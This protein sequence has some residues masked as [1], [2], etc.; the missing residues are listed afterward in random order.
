MNKA[1][2][3]V[4]MNP[5]VAQDVKSAPPSAREAELMDRV[6]KLEAQLKGLNGVV[7]S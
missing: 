1:M 6:S 7:V 3:L 4:G 2:K 5:S